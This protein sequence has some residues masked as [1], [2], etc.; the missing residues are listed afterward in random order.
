M[1]VLN[2][3]IDLC[4]TPREQ[5]TS[6]LVYPRTDNSF[7][8]FNGLYRFNKVSCK[9]HVYIITFTLLEPRN[10]ENT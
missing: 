10:Q 9:D 7:N 1:K 6:E 4:S 3:G 8:C 2:E 5:S